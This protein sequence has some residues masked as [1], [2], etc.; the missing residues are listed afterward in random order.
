MTK[1]IPKIKDYP[2]ITLNVT[3]IKKDPSNPNNMRLEQ[4]NGLEKSIVNFGRLKYIVVDQDNILIDGEHRLEVEKANGT[5]KVQV[6]QVPVK[7]EIERKMMRETLNQLHGDYDKQKQS[8]ELLAIF[9]NQ[10]LDELAELLGKPR[11]EFEN[12]ITRYNPEISFVKEE[13]ESKLP[14]LFDTE[15]FVKTGEIWQLGRHKLMCGDSTNKDDVSILMNG[16]K[17]DMVFTDPPYYIMGTSTGFTDEH[18]DD[19]MVRPFFQSVLECISNNIDYTCHAYICCNWRSYPS[20]YTVNRNFELIPRN[21]IVWSKPN[22]RLGGYYSSSHELLFFVEKIR[23]RQKLKGEDEQRL[24]RKL[25]VDDEKSKRVN[26]ESNVWV[27]NMEVSQT[28]RIHMAMK[29][30]SLSKKAITLSSDI[31]NIVLDP[32]MGSGNT[33]ITCEQTNRIC[34]GMEIDE[35]YCSVIIRRWEE[36][37]NRKAEKISNKGE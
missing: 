13:D 5:T 19:S 31:N 15:S 4:I 37:T 2:V 36:Y 16:K 24:R 8:S 10:K 20:Y 33:L 30:L 1:Q 35:H 32:F 3:D 18:V 9:E 11:E 6:I 28:T 12:L 7:N 26:G 34:Y 14:S 27:I 22:M 21:L 23:K 29:P 17:A 25:G